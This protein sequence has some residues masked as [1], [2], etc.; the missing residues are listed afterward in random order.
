MKK[1]MNLVNF[2]I[3]KRPET[4]KTFAKKIIL[5]NIIGTVIID[6]LAFALKGA[7]V[8]LKA[9]ISW[10]A[11]TLLLMYFA[12]RT[13]ESVYSAYR[14]YQRD[15]FNQLSTNETTEVILELCNATKSKVFK[16]E[17]NGTLSRVEHPELIQKTKNYIQNTWDLFVKLPILTANIIVLILTLICS[18]ILSTQTATPLE[19][20]L[21]LVMLL[22]SIVL[23]FFFS[24]QR[25]RVMRKFRKI[26]KENEAKVDVIFT[27]IKSTDFISAKDFEY[28]ARNFIK[29]LDSTNDTEKKERL[30][31]NKVFIKRSIVSTL[32]ICGMI[33]IKFFISK[34]LSLGSFFSII[35]LSTIYSTILSRISNI[36]Q[37]FE[38]VMNIIVDLETLFPDFNRIH[39]VYQQEINK[40][41]ISTPLNSV[42]VSEFEVS[43]DTKGK[44]TLINK[45]SITLQQGKTYM[46]YGHTGCGKS[47]LLNLL[48]GKLSLK[49]SPIHFSNGQTGY[50]NSIAYQTDKSMANHYVLNELTLTDDLE[51]ISV[52][53][54]Y[55]ILKGL[56]LYEELLS[57]IHDTES[58][59]DGLSDDEKIYKF[60]QLKKTKEFSSGQMQ[61]LA[62]TKLLYSLDDTIQMV[63]LDEPFN[64][65]DDKIAKTCIDFCQK[66]IMEQNRILIIATHQV[67]ICRPYAD[68]EISFSENLN[69]SFIS[70]TL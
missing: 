67:D 21:V 48:T 58:D 30:N 20:V 34:D 33:G 5:I 17:E 13:L 11:V 10:L 61:R 1:I 50:L 9:G 3:L 32:L 25:I 6:F 66:Y 29:L 62:L 42:S 7:E 63:A 19:T 37:N 46:V 70:I 28:H 57:M 16:E 51:K 40:T 41:L 39:T 52:P 43:Q 60:L 24:K 22:I 49:D 47:T 26:K 55:E 27:E 2:D 4:V 23:Y 56:H 38:D 53:K 69:K 35:T 59:I 12:E 14:E 68:Q 64:R 15:Q 65:L 8:S 18:I 31:L 36:S 54:L 44:F 45:N